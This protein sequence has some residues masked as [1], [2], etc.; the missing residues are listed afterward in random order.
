MPGIE[1]HPLRWA[2]TTGVAFAIGAVAGI[3]GAFAVMVAM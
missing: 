2:L 3:A 1:H